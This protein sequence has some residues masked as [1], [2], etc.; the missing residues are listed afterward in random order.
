ML[1]VSQGMTSQ[2][3]LNILQVPFMMPPKENKLWA[4]FILV[5]GECHDI[6][7]YHICYLWGY[8]EYEVCIWLID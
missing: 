7:E 4:D 2:I 8:L 3:K 5:N 6:T 1:M